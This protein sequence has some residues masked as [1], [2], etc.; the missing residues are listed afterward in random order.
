LQVGLGSIGYLC[1]TEV[2]TH[3]YNIWGWLL[4]NNKDY[5]RGDQATAAKHFGFELA[6]DKQ[7]AALSTKAYEPQ[8]NGN[9]A[10]SIWK[11]AG[12]GEKRRYDFGYDN[13]N[14]LLK[15]D[16]TQLSG[17]TFNLS[18]GIDF[19]VRMGNGTDPLS[20]YDANGNIL[21]MQQKGIKG[22]QGN[23]TI[24][25]LSYSY[26]DH[27]N[28]L[29]SVSD[30]AN[31]NSSKLGDFKY[32]GSTKGSIDYAYDVNGNLIS[33]QN[34][35]ITSIEYNHLNLPQLITVAGKGTI[36]YS[37]DAGGNKLKKVTTDNTTTTP[38]VTTTL[39]L[40]G[41]VY[42]NDTLQFIGHEEGRIRPK[43]DATHNLTGITW[44]YFLKDHL[45]NVRMVL[46]EETE[47]IPY[48]VASMEAAQATTEE[49][50][51]TNL[52]ITRADKPSGYPSDTYTSPN[53]KVAK[54]RGDGQKIGPA[55][56]L[57]VM[58]GDKFN[59]RVN[60]WYTTG[61]VT[62]ASP[63]SPLNELINA[64]S[65]GI[66]SLSSKVTASE[67][68]TSGVLSPGATQFLNQQ[69]I[70]S[71]RPKAY[72]A[73]LLLDEQFKLVASSSSSEPVGGNEEF[74][75]HIRN[76]LP[77]EKN[78]YLYIYVS[79]ETPNL[80]VFFDNLQVTHIKGPLLEETHYYPFGLTMAGISTKAAGGVENK[81]KF[82][83]KELNN[84]EFSDGSGLEHYDFGARN[85]D[86]QIGRWHT[87][88]PLAD[89]MRRFSP[90]NYAFDNPLR[91]IDPD[92][93]KPM[94]W[95]EYKDQYGQKHVT[96]A[97]SV[98]D[99]KSAKAWAATMTAN[100]GAY[101]DVSYVGK[102]GVVENGYTDANGKVQPYQLNDGGTITQLEYGKPSVTKADVANTEPQPNNSNTALDAADKI[103]DGVGL[104][105]SNIDA[106]VAAV[107]NS[108]PEKPVMNA[109]GTIKKFEPDI[110]GGV[111][112]LG[113][114]TK[115]VG[116]VTGLVD[117]GI[118]IKQAYD[119][120]TPGNVTK[121]VFKTTLA[122][123]EV[124]G[125]VNPAVGIVI[126]VLDMTGAT[127]ALFK[128]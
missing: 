116:I 13:V 44:D 65:S 121:A 10:G 15:A 103:N 104:V 77:I 93:M 3:D 68:S 72:V 70:V 80:A 1:R 8:Y 23:A 54:V 118:A 21:G 2:A 75:T 98:T 7:T 55:I 63:V 49:V 105:N 43:R 38:K 17:S 96:W 124:Y 83:G 90:Y 97:E 73:W 67:L 85:Y 82:N 25:A 19:S 84:K 33:D 101:N 117:A 28:K 74:T 56:T 34:K 112:K 12:D 31:D 76:N 48:P 30:A 52:N 66:G 62:P 51:Y 86:P 24:D 100:G 79:N 110:G 115:G 64:L 95:V 119:N 111:N 88:D 26:Y 35:K 53:D 37:Y 22:L 94:D 47:T 109:D 27:S 107:Q 6:Y 57:K 113:Q 36:A 18:A 69:P 4:G 11:S 78:G 59:L 29:K 50:L 106:G 99:Q 46:T 9:I 14:R 127:D 89:Q 39:Y 123:L 114:I 41:L 61:G 60:S 32:D 81:Y 128:W 92:G 87:V 5:V 42:Q 40:G 108:V 122:A 45:G 71:G 91:Y 16:F 120:P 125:R 20:A 126:G 102:T 58:A